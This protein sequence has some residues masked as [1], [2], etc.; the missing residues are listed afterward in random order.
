MKRRL[1]GSPKS[2][3]KK[4]IL[5]LLGLF[6]AFSCARADS[7]QYTL[8]Q[9]REQAQAGWHETYQAYGRT[10][11]ADIPIQVPQGEKFPAL[12][13]GL[14]PALTEL[15]V[16]DWHGYLSGQDKFFN[17]AGFF[18]W[19]S[20]AG[21]ITTA[22]ARRNRKD[23]VR[24]MDVK[25]VIRRFNQ[26]DWDT[27]YAFNNP[28]TVREADARMKAA[29]ARYFPDEEIAL[30]PHWVHA[31]GEMR[32]YDSKADV[33]SGDPWPE[34]QGPLMVYF[35]QVLRGIPL[36][37]YS[38]ES[39]TQ[40]SGPVKKETRTYAGGIAILQGLEDIGMEGLFSSMQYSLLKEQ[41]EI[42][43]DLPLCSL[44]QAMGAYEELIAQGKLRTVE[45]L[46]LGYV[47]WFNKGEPESFTLLPAWVLEG[48][49]F[50]EADDERRMPLT[51]SAAVSLEYGPILV[52]AQTG[53]FISPW[54]TK[55]DR[56][57]QQPDILTAQCYVQAW[58]MGNLFTA[59]G[60][61][62][63]L[64]E[65]LFC[66]LGTGTHLIRISLF[67]LITISEIPRRIGFQNLML[68]RAGRASWLFSQIL[69]CGA[70][71]LMMALVI[72]LLLT[73]F[74]CPVTAPGQGF[75]ETALI[76][77]EELLPEEAL[78]PAFVREHFTPLTA[79]L[80][81]LVPLFLFWFVMALVI[82]LCGLMGSSL[83]GVVA[84][85]LMLILHMTLPDTGFWAFAPPMPAAYATFL[86]ILSGEQ[87]GEG[88]RLMRAGMGYGAVLI[89]LMAALF[90]RSRR[91]DLAFSSEN[92][93]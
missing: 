69:Y 44:K 18:R 54:N 81:A 87:G 75:S 37:G 86:S 73:V 39:F 82:L 42:A 29:W 53:E 31:Y 7:P 64:L 28:A 16:T 58:G 47:A 12:A 56:S 83:A 33:Y 38:A 51:Q 76:Q 43:R 78:A 50:R 84:Y 71:A 21:E 30:I 61:A 67:F 27:P 26:L 2:M 10:I 77:A 9:V 45:S 8:S 1:K 66:A 88:L 25:P 65:S 11:V 17:E 72:T 3:M 60:H 22:A 4:S 52:N 70:M 13:A 5:L 6:T 36:L 20:P 41:R 15:P 55:A 49:L 63:N 85:S 19:D 23:P 59:R 92:R 24:G 93:F 62:M 90:A 40:Y 89:V 68:I 48:E 79:C 32:S 57:F 80:A 74:L 34:F 91:M 35:D 14:M 46:R